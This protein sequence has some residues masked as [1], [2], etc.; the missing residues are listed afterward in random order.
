[1]TT[2]T[3]IRALEN[4]VLPEYPEK[5][6]IS[7]SNDAEIALFNK[8][9]AIR[10]RYYPQAKTII[11]SDL[12]LDQKIEE[13]KKLLQTI[14]PA[15]K[16]ILTK[17]YDF[18]T[19]RLH[20]LLFNYLKPSFPKAAHDTIHTRILWFF[21]EMDKLRV[22]EQIVDSEWTHNRDESAVDFDDFAWWDNVN[23]LVKNAVPSGVFTE[24]SYERLETFVDAEQSKAIRQYW[25]DHPD[26]FESFMEKL[27]GLENE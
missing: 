7:I 24:S 4:H 13:S 21:S 1:M 17:D 16:T 5:A 15:E 19:L 6:V 14:S 25:K 2:K 20:N 22:K 10:S 9:E 26:E 8:A 12:T 27:K 3:K 23:D 18:L 11:E